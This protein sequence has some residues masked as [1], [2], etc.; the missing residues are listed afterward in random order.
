[1]KV[2]IYADSA[3]FP[4]ARLAKQNTSTAVITGWN[5]VA[6]EASCYLVSGTAYWLA[7]NSDASNI[8]YDLTT[9][10]G[11]CYVIATYA[12]FTFPDPAGTWG[13]PF[14]LTNTIGFIAGWGLLVVPR[15]F[16]FIIG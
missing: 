3:G 2:G 12:T 14:P 5:T 15:S 7:F 13:F 10:P 1:V 4:G 8:G 9:G 11:F 6:L 16:G